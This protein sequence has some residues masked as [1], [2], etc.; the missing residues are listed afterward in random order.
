MH[1]TLCHVNICSQ[2]YSPSKLN[3]SIIFIHWRKEIY[4]DH[5]EKPTEWPTVW[6][7]INYKEERRHD[8]MRAH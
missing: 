3:V 5:T 6:T 1:A 4:I 2:K 7:S 8:K